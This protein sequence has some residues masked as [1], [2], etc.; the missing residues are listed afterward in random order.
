MGGIE[1]PYHLHPGD[2]EGVIVVSEETTEHDDEAMIMIIN[3]GLMPTRLEVGIGDNVVWTNHV[4]FKA[5][6]MSG[7]L[8]SMSTDMTGQ[9][10]MTQPETESTA[11]TRVTGLAATLRVEVTHLPTSSSKVMSLTELF[12]DDGHY[13]AEFLPTAPGDYRFRFFG[14]IKGTEI[15]ETFDSG[16]GTFDTVIASDAIQFPVVLESN[17]EIQN[18]T[19]GALDAVQDIETELNATSSTA[20]IGMILGIVGMSFGVIAA[21][22]SIFAIT[23]ARRRD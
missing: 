20:S 7:P 22:T 11:G 16:P 23:I 14:S 15:N 21:A 10:T 18:A 13:L 19:Q 4:D 5:V 2:H 6:V 3:D 12:G 1:I 9:M 17:R 8:S